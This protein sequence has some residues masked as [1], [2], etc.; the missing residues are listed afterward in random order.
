MK[1]LLILIALPCV[2][3][4][5]V[6]FSPALNYQLPGKQVVWNVTA[7]VA[8]TAAPGVNVRGGDLYAMLT[9]KGIGWLTQSQAVAVLQAAPTK[10]WV[11]ELAKWG[12]YLSAGAAFLLTTTVIKA[13]TAWTA[14]ITT[15]SGALNV[16]VPLATKAVPPVPTDVQSGLLGPF[17]VVPQGACSSAIVI[18]SQGLGFEGTIP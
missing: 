3:Q 10:S 13:S 8:N 17:L 9:T 7:C 16:I 12:G 14:G 11:A 4:V 6:T 15:G 1:T 18:G 5:K 2:A